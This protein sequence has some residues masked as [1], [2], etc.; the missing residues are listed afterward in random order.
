MFRFARKSWYGLASA[1]GMYIGHFMAWMAASILYAVQLDQDPA[2]TAVLPGPLAYRACG[3]AGLLC[4]IAAGWTTANPTLYRAG[5]AFQS[6]NPRSSRFKVTLLTGLIAS[7]S[8]IFPIVTMRLLDF[9]ALWGMIL[10]PM[11]AVIFVDFWVLPRLGLRSNFAESHRPVHQLGGRGGLGCK[12]DRLHAARAV[13]RRADLLCQPPR[14][15][16]DRAALCRAQ[17]NLSAR[18][19]GRDQSG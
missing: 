12:R 7:V 19:A 11:G 17:Q 15:V 3:L 16:C 18:T 8:A 2:N 9:V 13:W 4:V 6:L 1:A 10:M 5:L 14:L